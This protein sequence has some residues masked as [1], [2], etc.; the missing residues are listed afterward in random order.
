MSDAVFQPAWDTHVWRIANSAGFTRRLRRPSSTFCPTS[1]VSAD[2]E[3]LEAIAK[4]PNAQLHIDR[5]V[6]RP[7]V[8]ADAHGAAATEA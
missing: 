7:D 1:G 5:I 6:P 4:T 3:R 2:D 8:E